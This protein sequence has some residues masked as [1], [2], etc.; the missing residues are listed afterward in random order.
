MQRDEPPHSRSVEQRLCPISRTTGL[1]PDVIVSFMTDANVIAICASR[2]LNIPTIVSERNQPDRPELGSLQKF[3]SRLFYPRS[4][5]LVVQTEDLAARARRAF[6]VR[7]SVIQNPLPLEHWRG[8]GEIEAGSR[9]DHEIVAA[10]RLV[11]QKGF[12]ILI[13]SF[14][15]I[16]S[17]YPDWKLT[18]YGEGPQRPELEFL[19]S[20]HGLQDRVRLPGVMKDLRPVFCRASLFVLPSRFEGYPNVLLEALACGCPVIATDC[21]GACAEILAQ[22]RYGTLVPSESAECLAAAMKEMLENY[23]RRATYSAR[24]EEA[25]EG[26]DLESIANKWIKIFTETKS[27]Q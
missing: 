10:G 23:R 15:R 16:S 1:H 20:K 12:D 18:V 7:V 17:H 27:S 19:V 14:S 3:G 24:A 5:A 4:S 8:A 6:K 9:A 22:G 13:E 25:L 21:P 26:L 11:P 2:G